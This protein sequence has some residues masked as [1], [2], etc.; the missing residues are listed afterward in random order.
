MSITAFQANMQACTHNRHMEAFC[1]FWSPKVWF[2]E[3]PPARASIWLFLGKDDPYMLGATMLWWCFEIKILV[4]LL[5]DA[6]RSAEI[7]LDVEWVK[8]LLISASPVIDTVV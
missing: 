2:L 8:K 6:R 4:P 3:K 5:G 7:I 1:C